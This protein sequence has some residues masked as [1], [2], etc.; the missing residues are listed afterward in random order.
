VAPGK[1][2]PARRRDRAP[3]PPPVR[4]RSRE[5][6]A[7]ALPRDPFARR[8]G[9]G[10]ARL[11]FLFDA[12]RPDPGSGAPRSPHAVH[13]TPTP[14]AEP[15]PEPATALEPAPAVDAEPSLELPP[16]PLCADLTPPP[17]E[18]P[19][20][21]AAVLAPL[22]PQVEVPTMHA[23]R[24]VEAHPAPYAFAPP[25]HDRPRGFKNPAIPTG[26]RAFVS[27]RLAGL[28]ENAAGLVRGLV[29]TL[30]SRGE[31]T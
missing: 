6:P 26:L 18:P 30:F 24:P 16:L 31:R 13:V 7:D 3:E 23:S 11:D 19:P 1:N 2:T 15:A 14:P 17:F 9:R 4:D 12:R 5:E 8:E 28:V 25:P 10:S 20:A 27:P 21:P 29:S 22:T